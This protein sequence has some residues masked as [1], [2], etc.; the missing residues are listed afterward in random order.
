M[1]DQTGPVE[2]GL[3]VEIRRLVGKPGDSAYLAREIVKFAKIID[4][5]DE[6]MDALESRIIG[7]EAHVHAAR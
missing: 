2:S 3:P 6:R 4:E 5:A 7:L 1:S